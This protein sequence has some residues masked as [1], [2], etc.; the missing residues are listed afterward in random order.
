MNPRNATAGTI[1]LLDPAEVRA[2]RLGAFFYDVPDAAE[3]YYSDTLGVLEELG[4]PVCPHIKKASNFKELKDIISWWDTKRL[5]MWFPMDGLVVKVDSYAHRKLLGFTSKA[6]SWAIA[7]KF[8]AERA[9]TVLTD[10]EYSL[11][12]TGVITPVAHLKPVVLSGTR[13]S[14]ASLHNWDIVRTLD[15]RIGD[16]VVVEKAGE[17]IPQIVGVAPESHGR[18]VEGL[19]SEIKLPD[20]CPSCS[21]PLVITRSAVSSGTGSGM[22]TQVRCPNTLQCPGQIAARLEH[23]VS[24][25]GM[26]IR[27]IGPSLAA[28]LVD[29][30]LVR[31]Y[32]DLY[33]LTEEM[34][35]ELDG[36]GPK[37]AANITEG[38][39]ASRSRPLH[40]LIYALGLPY[41]GEVGART[42]AEYF[43][44]LERMLEAPSLPDLP[45]RLKSLD[46]IGEKAALAIDAYFDDVHNMRELS[47]L[48]L[49]GVSVPEKKETDGPLSGLTFCITGKLSRPREDVENFIRSHGGRVVKSVSGRLS[50][51]VAGE[52]PGSKLKKAQKL[53]VRVISEQELHAMIEQ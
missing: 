32:S 40:R 15:V 29:S 35:T 14:R 9:T 30:G 38:I 24:R 44:S 28:K 27:S 5:E 12:R 51:L 37:S 21:T 42:L 53:G 47:R 26:D 43:G 34:L 33:S 8:R 13:V 49:L 31:N 46:G 48:H 39:Q 16:L 18:R 1:H 20:R 36:I 52:R 25:K 45:D 19:T 50:Y 7:Y 4:I 3:E 2:R 11:G 41:M 6:P 23:F 17:I 10:I 22:H